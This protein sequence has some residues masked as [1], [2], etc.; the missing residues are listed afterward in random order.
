MG[1]SGHRLGHG[2]SVQGL[3]SPP[4]PKFRLTGSQEPGLAG[5][6]LAGNNEGRKR[7]QAATRNKTQAGR[8]RA[9]TA[10]CSLPRATPCPGTPVPVGMA[11][12]SFGAGCQLGGETGAGSLPRSPR[13]CGGQMLSH[14]TT[15]TPTDGVGGVAC[16]EEGAFKWAAGCGDFLGA[17]FNTVVIPRSKGIQATQ[18]GR[19]SAWGLLSGTGSSGKRGRAGTRGGKAP[20]DAESLG[21]PG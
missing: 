17:F 7:S 11:E 16:R 10:W 4:S 5:W 19:R 14:P 21:E 12:A 8:G 15:A 9:R 18:A 1:L 20:Q 6:A 13:R 3:A 2:D